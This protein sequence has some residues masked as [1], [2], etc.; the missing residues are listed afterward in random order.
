[1]ILRNWIPP[2]HRF[3][4]TDEDGNEYEF[5]CHGPEADLKKRLEA[6]GLTVN[7]IKPE[8][9]SK[10]QKR[11]SDATQRAVEQFKKGEK[12]IKFSQGIWKDLKWHLFE[13][14]NGKCAY[15]ESKVLH[16]DHGSVEHFRPKGKVDEDPA[17]PGY[18]W[19]AYSIKNLLPTCTHCNEAPGKLTHF[20]V[21]GS[22]SRHYHGW[23]MEQPLLLNPYNSSIDPYEHLEFTDIGKVE[24]RAGSEMGEQSRK[25]YR[26]NRNG[27]SDKRQAALA[28][29]K[30]DFYAGVIQQ[31]YNFEHSYTDLRDRIV[32]GD[33]EYSA[34]QRWE[35]ER[36]TKKIG[37][38]IQG[39][40]GL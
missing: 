13:L 30:K 4:A 26:L 8:P 23:A 28:Q 22:H 31:D 21:V 3:N 39:L 36:L 29:V 7:W 2:D 27:L 33:R 24:P 20:P 16:I 38:F 15:C 35:L 12:P 5:I 9:F 25:W 18:F 19:L 14:F 6:K 10:W 17:H 32:L 1:M 11:A 34:A 37:G 40:P